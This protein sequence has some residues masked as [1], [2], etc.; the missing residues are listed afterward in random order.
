MENAPCEL[1]VGLGCLRSGPRFLAS[2]VGWG[3]QN[4]PLKTRGGYGLIRVNVLEGEAKSIETYMFVRF[5]TSSGWFETF[6][7]SS[8]FMEMIQFDL[9]IF[10]RWVAITHQL[11][12]HF[13]DLC[14][15]SWQ[16]GR[17]NKL[18]NWSRIIIC[19][20]MLERCYTLSYVEGF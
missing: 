9:R 17:A 16:I 15:F 18:A 19:S 2:H 20:L 14:S 5:K 7:C 3:L 10:F 8:L 11:A 13:Y 12:F 4:N 1:V 6:L